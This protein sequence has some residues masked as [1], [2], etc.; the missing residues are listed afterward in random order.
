MNVDGLPLSRGS[1]PTWSRPVGQEDGVSTQKKTVEKSPR[2]KILN[3]SLFF[4]K[5]HSPSQKEL[6]RYRPQ[7]EGKKLPLL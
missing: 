4:G 3:I 1:T 2:L 5:G 7:Q 6:A